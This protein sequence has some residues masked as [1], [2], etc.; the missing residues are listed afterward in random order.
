MIKSLP[1]F[2]PYFLIFLCPYIGSS[3]FFPLFQQL[4]HIIRLFLFHSL[5]SFI[6]PIFSFPHISF[7][8]CESFNHRIMAQCCPTELTQMPLKLFTV[9]SKINVTPKGVC[10][11][12]SKLHSIIAVANLL[13]HNKI[14]QICY[15]SQISLQSAAVNCSFP[16]NLI[17]LEVT[18]ILLAIVPALYSFSYRSRYNESNFIS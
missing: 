16:E 8:Q 6:Y 9:A 1:S 3:I 17:S 7:P 2:V 14:S 11:P 18:F 5:L 13:A 12:I 4:F 10:L 15:C